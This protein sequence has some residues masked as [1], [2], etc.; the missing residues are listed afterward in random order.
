VIA[1]DL[2]REVEGVPK[3]MTEALRK[4]DRLIGVCS[5]PDD[6]YAGFK[7]PQGL[8]RQ[9]GFADMAADPDGSI[10]R[11]LL[12]LPTDAI[13]PAPH[14]LSVTAAALYLN[15]TPEQLFTQLPRMDGKTH[16]AA[17]QQ[18][19][20]RASLLKPDVYGHLMVHYRGTPIPSLTMA[21]FMKNRAGNVQLTGKLVFI[22]V[23]R[24]TMKDFRNTPLA[25]NRAGV[26]IHAEKAN[27]LIRLINQRETP[28]WM[29]SEQQEWGWILFWTTIAGI[30]TALYFPLRSP[31]QTL[32]GLLRVGLV[33]LAL[34][35]SCLV[36]FMQRSG[37]VPLI[38][39]VASVLLSTA[40]VAGSSFRRREP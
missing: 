23:T 13:C 11:N 21:D 34:Y 17:Y 18:A 2:I 12:N 1:V 30:T 29:W 3:P 31:L 38:P 24:S 10:R 27:H 16:P 26:F 39:A 22:G 37:W 20:E 19:D 4:I 28:I 36:I 35:G 25:T 7:L 5:H 40:A 6:Q 32:N 9:V 14:A 8:D 15:R 33:L